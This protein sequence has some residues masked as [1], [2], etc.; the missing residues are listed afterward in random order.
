MDVRSTKQVSDWQNSLIRWFRENGRDYPW[1]RTTDPYAILVSELMLQQTR[2]KAVLEKG[3]YENWMERFPDVATL[4]GSEVESVLKAWEGLGYYNRAR[5]LQKAARHIEARCGGEFPDTLEEIQALPGV[6]PYTAGAVYSFAFDRRA[7]IVDGNV[8]RVLARVF[9]YR[10]PADTSKARKQFWEWADQLTPPGH[11]RIYNS[12]IMELGQQ[13]CTKSNPACPACPV[14]ALCS[15]R[16]EP[17]LDSIPAKSRR[18]GITRKRE[19]VLAW[20]EGGKILLSREDGTR[21][22]GLWSLPRLDPSELRLF[23][24]VH[25][26][27]Y[28][29]TRYQVTLG[30]YVRHE[31]T[32]KN[33]P[34]LKNMQG[35]WF[36][37][38]DELPALGAPYLRAIRELKLL[39]GPK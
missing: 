30:V 26:L 8:I 34:I 28:P 32:K 36:S 19:D 4:A 3:Y 13:V 1:R 17:D 27:T 16:G 38:D 33:D 11:A 29:I 20:T 35:E 2:I 22:R 21:R 39:E 24:K 23:R 5:N 10:D 12:A 31:K 25:E 37:L 7:P 9:S 6:G 18:T 14:S 15:S